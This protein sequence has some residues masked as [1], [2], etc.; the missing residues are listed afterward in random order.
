MKR[1][2]SAV[3]QQRKDSPG[4]PQRGAEGRA[5]ANPKGERRRNA[6]AAKARDDK[7]RQLLLLR[8]AWP[9]NKK[10]EGL[11]Q[12]CF[13]EFFY[14]QGK[15]V[16]SLGEGEQKKFDGTGYDS[17]L[18]DSLERDIVSRNPNVHW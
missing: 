4:L 16:D 1:P 13:I 6:P 10:R 5:Q 18:V 3:K 9:V 15:K 11:R 7:V 17:D 2:S 8:F 12:K 14:Y